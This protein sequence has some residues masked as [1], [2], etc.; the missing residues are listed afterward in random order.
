MNKLATKKFAVLGLAA[1]CAAGLLWM[2]QEARPPAAAGLAASDSSAQASGSVPAPT[3]RP[4]SLVAP[5]PLNRAQ[6]KLG[7]GQLLA[8]VQ[9]FAQDSAAAS[10]SA[11][12]PGANASGAHGRGAARAA[13]NVAAQIA[14]LDRVGIPARFRDGEKVKVNVDLALTHDEVS[15]P[16]LLDRATAALRETL[17]GAGVQAQQINGSPSLEAAVPLAQLEWVAGLAPVAQISLMAMTT[18]AA[19]SDG[20]TASDIDR[21]RSLGNYD[22]LAQ[23]LRRDLR[24]EGLTI[25]IVDHFND[26]NGA[27][28]GLQNA[29]EWPANSDDAPGKLTL[30]ASSNGVFGYRGIAHGNA[31]T[32]IAYDI[33]PA[34]SFRL[35]DNVGVADWVSAIQD[36]ANL[37]AQNVA[38]GEPRAQV[39]TASLGFNL[40]APG[41]GTGTGS[42]LRGLYEAIDAAKRNGAIVLNAAGNEAQNHWDG[43]STGGAGANV[44]Q[45]F[46]VGNRDANGVEIVESVNPLT[47]EGR[48]D[49]CIPV[50]AKSQKDKDTFEFDVW[51]GWNDWTRANNVTDADYKV[52]LVRWADAVTRRQG[53]RTVVVT[54]ARWVAAAQSDE[55]Q[56]GGAGQQPLEFISYQAPAADKTTAC[57]AQGFSTARFAGGGKFGVRITRKT[58][59]AANFLRLMNSGYNFGYGQTERSLIHPADSASVVT[60]AALDAATSNLEDYSSRGPV[61]ADGG[62]RPNGQAAGNAKPDLANFA[63]V[64]TVSYGDNEFNGTSSATPHVAALALLGLQHQR[65]LTNATV[66]APLPAGATQAQKDARAALLKQRNV[67]LADATYDSLV[68]VASTGGNDLGPVGFDAS[69]GNGRLKFHANSESCFLSALYD[70]QYRSLLPAQANPLPAGQKSYEQLLAES[71]AAC[72]AQ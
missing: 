52:E 2:R 55:A 50:G 18:T 39:I 45:D 67:A 35:Y 29:D 37:N 25:A 31:V 53:G 21:L 70:A 30:T 6:A 3:M 57:D 8:A 10:S 9:S 32:E 46:V 34:A 61:L 60:V 36:A 47:I 49:G 17:R 41:D 51:L 42:D 43:D 33:A 54:P 59:G 23:A 27:V 11:A 15:N 13:G 44:L 58:A 66:P 19:F 4:A 48:Y 71:S 16:V 56:N 69:Y 64:D 12:A 24:G 20:A 22:Q 7:S 40:N 62:A 68:Y 1:A 65:Q 26:L 72:S 28:Q 63:N 5:T 38:Q 14:A